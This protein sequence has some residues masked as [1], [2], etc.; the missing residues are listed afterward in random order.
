VRGLVGD[1]A[2]RDVAAVQTESLHVHVLEHGYHHQRF[3]E[4]IGAVGAEVG[5]LLLGRRR[6]ED[7]LAELTPREREVLALMAEGH[8]NAELLC[9]RVPARGIWEPLDPVGRAYAGLLASAG[10]RNGAPA[11]RKTARHLDA[12]LSRR[13]APA[14]PRRLRLPA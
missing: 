12:E 9:I 8:S 6:R 10:S 2:G 11:A 1:V 5:G 3:F 7:P 14:P 13:Q 4:D